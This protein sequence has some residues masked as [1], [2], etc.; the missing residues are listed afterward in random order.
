MK[1]RIRI[2][3]KF[4]GFFTLLLFFLI[5]ESLSEDE[6]IK[7]VKNELSKEGKPINSLNS[8]FEIQLQSRRFVPAEDIA[9]AI[10]SHIQPSQHNR[11][12]VLMQFY[13]IPDATQRGILK[14]AAVKLLN[15]IP[16][17]AW[18]VSVPRGL[19]QAH[20]TNANV[21]WIGPILPEDKIFP[22][23]LSKGIASWPVNDVNDDGTVNLEVSIFKDVSL[24]EARQLLQGMGAVIKEESTISHL[25]TITILPDKLMDIAKEDIVRWIIEERPPK[26]PLNDGSRANVGADFVQNA[27]YNL[28]GLNVDVGIWDGGK[29][30]TTHDD[31]GTRVTVADSVSVDN[32]ATH[33]AGTMGGDGTLSA[34]AGGTAFQWKGMA[35]QMDIISYYWDNNLTDHNVAINTYGIEL[36]QN[37]WGYNLLGPPPLPQYYGYYGWDAPEYD[38]IITGL[39]GKRISVVFAAG[40][41]RNDVS[42]DY[43]TIG[44]P[45]TAKNIVCVGAIHSDNDSMTAFSGWGPMNDGRIKPDVVAP[46]DEV[47]GDGGIKSTLPVDTYGVYVGTSMAAPCVSGSS[48]LIIEDYRS[49]YLGVDP[50]PSTVKA[51]LIHEAKDLGNI[52]PDYSYGY[53]DIQIQKSIDKLRTK[54]LLE[55]EVG[56]LGTD[57]YTLNV[58]SG[59]TEVKITLV[60]DD[61]PA[62]E[63]AATTLVNDLDLIVRDPNNVRYYPWTLNPS[64]PSNPAVQTQEDH[65]N[66]VEQVKVS[67]SITSGNWTIEVYGYNISTVAPQKYSLIFTPNYGANVIAKIYKDTGYSQEEKFF[68]RTNPVY[69]EAYVVS[70]GSPVTGATVNATLKL[71]N[72]TIVTTLSLPDVGGGYYRNFWDSTGQ[73]PDVYLAD[74]RVTSPTLNTQRYFHLYPQSGVSSYSLDY[75]ADGNNDYIL[76]NKHLIAVYDGRLQTNKSLLYLEQKDTDVNY[77]FA[78]ISDNNSIGTGEIT[79]TNMKE[80]KFSAFAFSQTGENKTSVDLNMSVAVSDP[81]EQLITYYDTSNGASLD[82]NFLIDNAQWFAERFNPTDLNIPYTLTKISIYVGKGLGASNPLIVEIRADSGGLPGNTVLASESISASSVPSSSAW[83]EVIFTNQ[84]TLEQAGLYWLVLRNIDTRGG[85]PNYVYTWTGDYTSPSYPGAMA[86]SFNQGASW[87]NGSASYDMV[88]RAYGFP[89]AITTTFNLSIKMNTENVDYLVYKA[90]GFDGFI[91]DINDIFSPIS[92]SLGASVDDDRY[93]IGD[94]TDNLSNTLTSGT[95]TNFSALTDAQKYIAIYDNSNIPDAVNNNIIS[96]VYFP[97]VNTLNFSGVGAWYE[98]GRHGLRIRY[99]TTTATFTNEAEYILAFSQGNYSVI[100]QWMPTIAG[101]SL[102]SPNFMTPSSA[103]SISVLPASWSIGQVSEGQFSQSGLFTVTNNGT[104]IETFTLNIAGPSSPS[105]WTAGLLPGNEVYVMKGLFGA[106]SSNPTGLFSG[107]DIILIGTPSAATATQFG[108]SSLTL[109]GV[110]VE[111]GGQRG[112]WFEFQAPTSTNVAGQEQTITVSVG[113]QA[114]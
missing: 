82:A 34:L 113:A 49:L 102:P 59:T 99:D 94:G 109:N 19:L 103:L 106:T 8:Q 41:D 17:K 11:V 114:P 78:G 24:S 23:I 52:G 91:D 27:P 10:Q 48:S 93:H 71:S 88:F 54:S 28:S 96:W 13:D 60:W 6:D 58:P 46:G 104:V 22:P 97:N 112:L 73:T 33:V 55:D 5:G 12:H 79:T 67:G 30:D 9:S 81:T 100:D 77:S 68:D 105:L 64:N 45:S 86:Y 90:S 18:L 25:L 70:A 110:S 38:D 92:G 47:S 57:T 98:A 74:I 62:T 85:G 44:P 37:S 108:D 89:V 69:I 53:G 1:K 7:W 16:H 42:Y 4:L 29:V 75:D 35:A 32:H 31:F 26:I 87:T 83:L 72:G 101:G 50:L 63:G 95:W 111:V 65:T 39:Y 2:V 51:L 20:L 36:S 84:I 66:N 21:R 76:E 56:H 15:Y 3:L 107:D 43:D 80:I 14:S 61:E 40:N